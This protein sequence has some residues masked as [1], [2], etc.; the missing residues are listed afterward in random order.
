MSTVFDD[1]YYDCFTSNVH[2][3]KVESAIVEE[4]QKLKSTT[5]MLYGTDSGKEQG[6]SSSVTET[7]ETVTT[8]TNLGSAAGGAEAGS[9]GAGSAGVGS[10][11]A[12]SS[13]E[14]WSTQEVETNFPTHV[15]T[16]TLRYHQ[17]ASVLFVT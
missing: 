1:V 2:F 9:A 12:S 10:A 8:T 13:S 11:A 7:I 17:R 15:H 6:G 5:D 3:Q 14:S 4:S 16:L